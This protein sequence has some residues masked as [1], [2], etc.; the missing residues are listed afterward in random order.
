MNPSPKRRRL[1]LNHQEYDK[2]AA[3]QGWT[4]EQQQAEAL[5][6][7][8]GSLNRIRNEKASIGPKFLVQL[9]ASAAETNGLT[10]GQAF[11]RFFE[12][13]DEDVQVNAEMQVNDAPGTQDAA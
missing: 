10:R 12:I 7:D 11:E 4:I 3:E 1:V 5:G 8:R 2:Y 6:L 13:R 9:I